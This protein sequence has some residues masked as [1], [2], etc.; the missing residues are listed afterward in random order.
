MVSDDFPLARAIKRAQ[1]SLRAEITAAGAQTVTITGADTGWR[2]VSLAIWTKETDVIDVLRFNK[3]GAQL[4]AIAPKAGDPRVTVY[5]A[6]MIQSTYN[7]TVATGTGMVVAVKFP[8]WTQ[9]GSTKS[10]KRFRVNEVVYTPVSSAL[11]TP[12]MVAWGRTTLDN[13]I[14]QVLND[15]RTRQVMSRAFPDKLL[16]DVINP[17]LAKG[18]SLIEHVGT[19]SLQEN[20]QTVINTFYTTIAANQESAYAYDSSPV[21]ATGLAQFMP[22]TYALMAKQT[23]LEL[24]QEGKAGMQNLTN[25]LKAQIAYADRLLS[26]MPATIR[27]QYTTSPEIA[28]EYVVAA[29]NTGEGRVK[30][31]VATWGDAWADSHEAEI[32]KMANQQAVLQA[33]VT[34]TKKQVANATGK[35][36]T[37][38]KKL[39]VQQ[40]SQLATLTTKLTQARLSRLLPET[41]M[42]IVKYRVA[43]AYF[44]QGESTTIAM[45]E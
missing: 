43:A 32:K 27:A 25:A 36:K 7:V 28:E 13:R 10:T 12:E 11:R 39:L 18:L 15:F 5:Y 35:T 2:E 41:V 33:T 14:A 23:N 9:I 8:Y 31:V 34:K 17:N 44:R 16:S 42:Y 38:K 29:Y 30:R 45:G 21:G 19:T 1:E 26:A 22:A 3:K 40:Q 4:Q 37:T 6:N 20:T 24:V